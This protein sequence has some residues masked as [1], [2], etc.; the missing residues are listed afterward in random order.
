MLLLVAAQFALAATW[1]TWFAYTNVTQIARQGNRVFALSAGSLYSVDVQTEKIQLWDAVCGMHGTDIVQIA[2]DSVQNKLL[3][4]YRN[5]MADVILSNGTIRYEGG[6]YK[7]DMIASKSANAVYMY[8]G[9]AYL[10]MPYGVQVFDMKKEEFV[11][12]WLIGPEGSEMNVLQVFVVGSEVYAVT[13]DRLYHAPLTAN[14]PDY[15]RWQNEALPTSGTIY[16]AWQQTE[17]KSLVFNGETWSPA[18]GSGVKRVGAQTVTY[19]PEGPISNTVNRMFYHDG[20][21][22]VLQGG[23]WADRYARPASYS[24][25]ENGRWKRVNQLKDSAGLKMQD[26]MDMVFFPGEH[27]HYVLS[28]YGMGALEMR[29]TTIVNHW[30]SE[31]TTMIPAAV[32]NPT[33]YTRAAGMAF[34]GEGNLWVSMA[35]AEHVDHVVVRKADGSWI[36]APLR[37]ADGSQ[38]TISTSGELLINPI[39][40]R[41]KW[42]M[43]CRNP[44]AM[45]LLD[46]QGTHLDMSDDVCYP[47]N[48]WIDQTGGSYAPTFWYQITQDR[49]GGVWFATEK[50]VGYISSPMTYLQSDTITRLIISDENGEDCLAEQTIN[51]VLVDSKDRLWVATASRGVYVVEPSTQQLLAH[52]HTGN[53]PLPSNAIMALAEDPDHSIYYIATEFGIVTLTENA[54]DLEAELPGYTYDDDEHEGMMGSWKLHMAYD[55]VR[56][57]AVGNT[58]VYGIASESLFSVDKDDREVRKLNRLT[59]LS[60]TGLTSMWYDKK[61]RQLLILYKD[62]M[63]DLLGD[64]GRLFAIPDFKLKQQSGVSKVVNHVFIHDESA[65]MAMSFG[66]MKLNLLKREISDTYTLYKARVKNVRG[67]WVEVDGPIDRVAVYG[68]SIYAVADSLFFRASLRDNLVDY[69]VWTQGVAPQSGAVYEALQPIRKDTV[70][71]NDVLWIAGGS[72]GII[73]QDAMGKRSSYKPDG[74][75]CNQP[76]GLFATEGRLIMVPGGRWATEYYRIGRVMF[77]E[78][79]TWGNVFATPI[80]E[81]LGGALQRDYTSVA[82][83]PADHKH[84]WITGYGTGLVE[85]R[86]DMPVRL[87]NSTN[88]PLTTLVEDKPL[89]YCRTEGAT[90]DSKG[91]LWFMN[92]GNPKGALVTLSAKG[93]TWHFTPFYQNGTLVPFETPGQ[94]LVDRLRPNLKWVF[95]CRVTTGVGLLDDGGTPFDSSDDRTVFYSTFIDQNGRTLSPGIIYSLT[96]DMDGRIWVGTNE[97]LFTIPTT[98]DFLRSNRVHR[99]IINRLDDSGLADYLLESAVVTCMVHDGG[100]RHWI[101]TSGDGVYLITYEDDLTSAYT[102]RT[103]YHFTTANS[104]I[105]SDELISLAIQPETGEVFMGTGNGLA[106]FLSDAS[107]GRDD[108]SDAY[109][110]PN[111]VRPHYEGNIVFAGLKEDTYVKVTDAA[112]N[113]VFSTRSNGGTAVWNGKDA[114][115]RRVPG[116]VYRAFCNTAGGAHR[117]LKVLIAR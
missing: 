116:G 62:G 20:C 103:I 44:G 66:I 70:Q 54:T 22:Y 48:H 58:L 14:L 46:D 95:N 73:R 110:Y 112:G 12:T 24:I 60:S 79:D 94:V 117:I 11:D 19:M 16:T 88:S 109:V 45:V 30:T 4:L 115:G 36:S 76:Y 83:D 21:L 97:G 3:V 102:C 38:Y 52:Y 50:G 28:C 53:A 82:I 85:F 6:L 74:P 10:A 75:Y 43:S 114:S 49:K 37:L 17:N 111:P 32:A 39:D 113:L 56:E 107:A 61:S 15:T 65:Y 69:H 57:V 99:P 25:L 105:P 1:K 34:D 2:S 104:P 8:Q 89:E 87:F 41:Y 9:K 78:N 64:D 90:F 98:Y 71:D 93:D 35:G 106:S 72:Q 80:R 81:A 77:Y 55:L 101:G 23:R 42:L 84:Y 29:G 86:N 13:A 18:G 33:Y 91:N 63:F 100:N 31:N 59:G 26:L 51:N 27:D 68:D 7:K 5:G 96:Q 92:N 47:K 108:F 40:E 67:E